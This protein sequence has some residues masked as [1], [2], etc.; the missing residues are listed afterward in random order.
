MEEVDHNNSLIH[1]VG[2]DQLALSYKLLMIMPMGKLADAATNN[3]R[4]QSDDVMNLA[5]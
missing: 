1:W 2:G 3:K 5:S 4:R